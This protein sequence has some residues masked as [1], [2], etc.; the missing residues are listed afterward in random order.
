M[1]GRRAL[2]PPTVIFLDH[3]GH[4][5][6]GQLGLK[7]YLSQSDRISAV[8][9][10]LGPG[11]AFASLG[12]RIA[13]PKVLS[14]IDRKW[15]V[16]VLWN[17][18]RRVLTKVPADLL[19]A[20]SVRSASLLALI[21][22]TNSTPRI[23][24]MRDDL[25][26]VRNSRLKLAYMRHVVL[27]SFDSVIANS[28]W[29]ASTLSKTPPQM[30]VEIAYP[31]SGISSAVRPERPHNSILTITS[32]SRLAHWKGIHILLSAASELER[33]GYTGHFRLNIAGSSIHAEPGYATLLHDSARTLNS[34]VTFLGQLDEVSGILATS[35]IVVCASISPE[36]F[37]QVV[38]QSLAAG[39]TVVASDAGG[40]KEMIRHGDNGLLVTPD[41]PIALADALERLITDSALLS[42]L[43]ARGAASVAPFEDAA[44]VSVLDGLLISMAEP[45][46][47]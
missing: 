4:P 30:S 25:N 39:V 10:Q 6:G 47:S 8:V 27:P 5:G 26:P 34:D 7:R 36:P 16:F 18:L 40:P 23:Y 19:V 41:D 45:S 9:I 12:E 29:T 21:P 38:A 33:R 24:Y 2:R 28:R 42:R 15:T 11:E 43:G 3:S 22:R 14:T 44:T 13:P 37:G 31:V 35:D 17:R 46:R 1:T 20:N 32:L